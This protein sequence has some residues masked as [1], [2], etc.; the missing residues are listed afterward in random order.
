MTATWATISFELHD[1]PLSR[2]D[3]RSIFFQVGKM[4]NENLCSS[5]DYRTELYQLYSTVRCT[6]ETTR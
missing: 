1:I 5:E 4:S 6:K 3:A 2:T